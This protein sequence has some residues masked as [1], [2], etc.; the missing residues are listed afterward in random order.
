MTNFCIF[1]QQ[2]DFIHSI[3]EDIRICVPNW[4]KKLMKD[5]ERQ[6]ISTALV[7]LQRCYCDEVLLRYGDC[8]R[9][10]LKQQAKA[11]KEIE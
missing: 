3:F 7:W 8:A 10:R 4:L 11:K 9:S 2:F 1:R 5:I 6:I